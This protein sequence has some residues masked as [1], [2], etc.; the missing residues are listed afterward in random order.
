MAPRF[1]AHM[2]SADEFP[3]FPIYVCVH[4]G[5]VV[6]MDEGAGGLRLPAKPPAPGVE[7]VLG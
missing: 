3:G 7:H 5:E 4:D 2:R 1:Q 6:V